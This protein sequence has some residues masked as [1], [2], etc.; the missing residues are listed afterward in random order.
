M[1]FM[2]TQERNRT[3]SNPKL[4]AIVA[5]FEKKLKGQSNCKDA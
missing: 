5:R 4:I 1:T 3:I 2:M